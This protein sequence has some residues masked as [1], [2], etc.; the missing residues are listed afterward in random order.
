MAICGAGEAGAQLAATLRLAGNHLILTFIDDAPSL[1]GRTINGIKFQPP[2]VLSELKEQLDQVL[3]AIPSMS[4]LE[5]RLIVSELHRQAIPV[6]QIPSVDDLTSGRARIQ[7]LRPVAIEDLLGRDPV[8]PVPDLLGPGL[9]DGVVCVTGAGGS[10]GSEL[11]RQILQLS[12]KAL[13]L[14]ENSEPSLYALDQ[15][16]RHKLPASVS[17]LPWPR[18]ALVERVCNLWRS[19]RL[20]MPLLINMFLL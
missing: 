20:F 11:C 16:L 2:Q 15:E 18:V 19:D 4:R 13:V 9:R 3:L 5:R 12:P 7:S 8:S 17:L 10:I 6:L 14:L 1:W